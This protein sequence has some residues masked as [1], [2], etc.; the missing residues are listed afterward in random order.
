MELILIWFLLLLEYI[1]KN[2]EVLA[3]LGVPNYGDNGPFPPLVVPTSKGSDSTNY[4][5]EILNGALSPFTYI[6]VAGVSI[7]GMENKSSSSL[8]NCSVKIILNCNDPT[9]GNLTITSNPILSSSGII[10]ISGGTFEVINSQGGFSKGWGYG[11]F[12]YVGENSYFEITLVPVLSSEGFY[13]FEF[14]GIGNE[15]A[16]MSLEPIGISCPFSLSDILIDNVSWGQIYLVGTS[17]ISNQIPFPNTNTPSEDKVSSFTWNFTPG[18]AWKIGGL[19]LSSISD[20]KSVLMGINFAEADII[21]RCPKDNLSMFLSL[22]S[23][24]TLSIAQQITSGTYE[25]ILNIFKS[26]N[27][28][29][30]QSMPFK[31]FSGMTIEFTFIRSIYDSSAV[32]YINNVAISEIFPCISSTIDIFIEMNSWA[33]LF[34]SKSFND[35]YEYGSKFSGTLIFSI[36]TFISPGQCQN[37]CSQTSDCIFWS[38]NNQQNICSGYSS[39]NYSFQRNIHTLGIITGPIACPC[40]SHNV[41]LYTKLLEEPYSVQMSETNAESAADCQALVLNM[42]S[43]DSYFL[44]NSSSNT[45]FKQAV[46]PGETFSYYLPNVTIGPSVCSSFWY[47]Y[48]VDI[49]DQNLYIVDQFQLNSTNIEHL[50]QVCKVYCSLYSDCLVFILTSS[51]NCILYSIH[52]SDA[53]TFY[54]FMNMIIPNSDVI[55]M[56]VNTPVKIPFNSKNSHSKTLVH[57]TAGNI[58]VDVSMTSKAWKVVPALGVILTSFFIFSISLF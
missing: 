54:K 43:L 3:L 6:K 41:G 52:N 56:G 47:G 1:I 32:I 58:V 20:V 48:S 25:N 46:L 27:S 28:F 26:K 30:I 40:Y 37:T 7:C 29:Q 44:Y 15:K 17:W 33:P 45:C 34:I 36:P 39:E 11:I 55:V 2:N 4:R 42:A 31:I 18:S 10:D 51:Y 5:A 14:Y 21:L 13:T 49:N 12:P 57:V 35:C 53:N 23:S 22:S 19:M 16:T 38:Y 50:D 9:D 8:A 24:G